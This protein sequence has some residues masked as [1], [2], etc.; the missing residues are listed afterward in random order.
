MMVLLP[1]PSSFSQISLGDPAIQKSV[2]ITIDEQGSVHVSHEIRESSNVVNMET[3]DGTVSNLQ[4]FD[5]D[6]NDVEHGVSGLDSIA[7]VTIFSSDADVIVEYNLD[8]VLFLEDGMWVWD[9][10]YLQTTTF[11]LPESLDLVYVN[12]N[13]VLLRDAKGITCHGCDAKIE[14]ILDEQ[15]K[16]HQIQWED[17]TFDVGVRTT[18]I[19]LLNFDQPTKSISFN[20]EKENQ[21]VTLIIPLELLWEPYEVFLDDKKILKH[22]FFSNETHSWLSFRPDISGTVTIIGT[23][24]IPEFPII[25]PLFIGI[26]V[27]IAL[28]LKNKLNL[29]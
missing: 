21:L 7:G 25:A 28:Q 1:I 29:H 6:G 11:I 9:F 20:L 13:P 23:T 16:I 10:L 12:D 15:I 22:E 4:V 2:T 14:Y 5:E 27:I 3:I 17:R 24:V 26:A 19:S 18:E 8:D